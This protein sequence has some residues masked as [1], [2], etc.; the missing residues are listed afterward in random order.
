M[1]R[2]CVCV[3]FCVCVCVCVCVSVSVSVSVSVGVG[4]G[5]CGWYKIH[6][7]S[8]ITGLLNLGRQDIQIFKGA[9]DSIESQ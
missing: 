6:H 3:C 8:D 2:E 1:M 9:P 7:S 5:G 4:V